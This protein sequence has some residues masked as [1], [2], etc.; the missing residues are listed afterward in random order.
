[1]SNLNVMI[2]IFGLV[3][4]IRCPICISISQN[5]DAILFFPWLFSISIS[6]NFDA[7]LFFPWLFSIFHNV[8]G[9]FCL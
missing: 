1:V 7:I 3:E 8:V 4:L 5:F 2:P 9:A 6:Q